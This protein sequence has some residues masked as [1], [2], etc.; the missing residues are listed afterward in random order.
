MWTVTR[1]SLTLLA[2]LTM[3]LPTA[4]SVLDP[5]EARYEVSRGGVSLGQARFSLSAWGDSGCLAYK[6]V[7]EPNAF[8]RLFI[9]KVVDESY[10]CPDGEAGV[11]PHHFRHVET[12]DE[13][14][15]Y[16]LD[17]DWSAG[18]VTYNED[19]TF[20]APAGGVD[21]FLLQLS[22]R[23]WLENA[24]TAAEA[25]ERE[26]TIV[27][28]DEIKTYRLAV[29]TGG[30]IETPAGTYETIKLERIDDPDRQLI[31]W[32]APALD[33]LPIQVERHKKDDPV[34]RM[35]LQSYTPGAPRSE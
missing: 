6:G 4:A 1:T 33:F 26:F 34:I 11:R 28:E 13:A 17:F 20:D 8:I 35:R 31:F 15:S 19:K 12:S 29:T 10:F 18:E 3:A 32:A 27:D 22:A 16:T 30:K 5:F 24:E 9:G 25:G 14:D 7:A 23:L 2:L 21:P